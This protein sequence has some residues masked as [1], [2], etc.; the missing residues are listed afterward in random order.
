M[1]SVRVTAPRELSRSLRDRL[2]EEP[3]VCDLVVIPDAA[4]DGRGDVLVFEMARENANN[5]MR[6]LRHSGVPAQ[7]SIVVSEPLTVVSDA[8]MAAEE[9]APGHPSDG[10]LWAQLADRSREDARPSV[11]FF[12]FLLLATLI[13]GIGRLLDQPILIIGAMVVGPEFAPIAAI[14][15]AVVRRRRGI[16]GS[17]LGTLV[18]GFVACALIAWGVWAAAFG[19]GLITVEQAT[20]GPATEFI[21][22]PDI[23]SFIIALLAGIAGVLSLTTAKSSA[24]VGVFI[25]ITTVPAVGTIGL[26]LAV[27]AWDEAL[28]SAVQLLVNIAGLLIAGVVTLFVQLHLGRWIGRRAPRRRRPRPQEAERRPGAPDVERADVDGTDVTGVVGS[29]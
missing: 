23:W 24:L 5:I 14:C 20:T 9:A 12:V 21:V 28:G 8:A 27:G 18:G 13:A 17:A 3:T 10:V 22:S 4:L 6:L 25:S 16:A 15:Y 19:L 7:G 11:S 26:T 29:A 1:L 2:S